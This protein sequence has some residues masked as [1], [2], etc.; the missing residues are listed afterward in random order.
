LIEFFSFQT[1]I[2]TSI[3]KLVSGRKRDLTDKKIVYTYLTV[4]KAFVIIAIE[5]AFIVCNE[6][7]LMR[8]YIVNIER[9]YTH[10]STFY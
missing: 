4:S 6:I 8:L 9:A 10:L 1:Y 3:I 2:I 5:R 7:Y